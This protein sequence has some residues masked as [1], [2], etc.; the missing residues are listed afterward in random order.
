MKYVLL[1]LVLASAVF[2][3][4][5]QMPVVAGAAPLGSPCI[6]GTPFYANLQNGSMATCQQQTG[7]NWVWSLLQGTPGGPATPTVPGMVL[8]PPGAT[9]NT[10][11]T[12]ASGVQGTAYSQGSP[13]AVPQTITG[14]LQEMIWL[15][16]FGCLPTNS[17]AANN[18]P[19]QNALNWGATH[20]QIIHC[21][22]NYSISVPLTIG[23]SGS[24]EIWLEG[25]GVSWVINTPANT[26]GACIIHQ[27]N[28]A[29]ALFS[30]NNRTYSPVW[31]KNLMLYGGTNNVELVNNAVGGP[32]SFDHVNFQY[33]THAGVYVDGTSAMQGMNTTRCHW[34]AGST[35]ANAVMED[36]LSVSANP[37]VNGFLVGWTSDH[38]L[39]G[40][41]L[42][43]ILLDSDG[44]S[45]GHTFND[46]RIQDTAG[47]PVVLMGNIHMITFKNF[48]N[49]ATGFGD[50]GGSLT[51][52]QWNYTTGST[53]A[54]NS[55]AINVAST[56]NMKVGDILHI[57][58]A[59]GPGPGV[60]QPYFQADLDTTIVSC[61]PNACGYNGANTINVADQ[62]YQ[63]VTNV[64]VTNQQSNGIEL[65]QSPVN[66][67]GGFAPGG[68]TYSDALGCI[69]NFDVGDLS[70]CRY[71]ILNLANDRVEVRNTAEGAPV[72]DPYGYAGPNLHNG[73]G[74]QTQH[75]DHHFSLVQPDFHAFDGSRD[76]PTVYSG[77]PGVGELHWA[78]GSDPGYYCNSTGTYGSAMWLPNAANKRPYFQINYDTG[79]VSIDPEYP[80]CN[81][82]AANLGIGGGSANWVNGATNAIIFADGTA[83]TSHTNTLSHLM[84]ISGTLWHYDSA[85]VAHNLDNPTPAKVFV[86]KL[87]QTGLS[88][89]QNNIGFQCATGPNTKMIRVD[90]YAMV[91][92]PA[93]TSSTLG[94]GGGYSVAVRYVNGTNGVAYNM[95]IPCSTE[96]G[97]MGT[98]GNTANFVGASLTCTGNMFINAFATVEGIY[99]G[100]TSVGATPMQ[101][102]LHG[103][104]TIPDNMP[105]L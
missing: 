99:F 48:S 14:V 105:S 12:P 100:Y 23:P 41:G 43:G 25:E 40:G 39:M 20:A 90:L 5:P 64:G 101:Y 6:A 44:N 54:Q 80:C 85:G 34:T 95:T 60:N 61:T 52:L 104:I 76:Y 68:V 77:N 96:A 86:C 17:A 55:T 91:T 57:Q 79:T 35:T 36:A 24:G 9:S 31:F 51:N 3:Q 29:V 16:N 75:W 33:Y 102:E 62:I 21:S 92:Q 70:S 53:T 81:G 84:A 46:L 69:T 32:L 27:T 38:D 45:G 4:G 97:V 66:P 18:V 93:T 15:D 71:T 94:N 67:Q 65:R 83:P 59:T 98:S 89:P 11:G 8:L 88:A 26:P 2:A 19:C 30:I 28:P 22:G 72:Y 13:N 58:H 50:N 42:H 1:I 73:L 10:L 37:G 82:V 78:C 103:R 63:I 49:E 74:T 56:A 47:S 87:D 7:G